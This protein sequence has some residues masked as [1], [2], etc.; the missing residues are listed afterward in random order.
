[1]T[2]TAVLDLGFGVLLTRDA[3]RSPVRRGNAASPLQRGNAEA[4]EIAE[5][6]FEKEHSAQRDS[7]V[8]ASSAFPRDTVTIGASVSNALLARLALLVPVG[9]VVIAATAPRGAD[10]LA[11]GIPAAV[12]LAGA[13]VAYGCLAAALRGWPEWVVPLLAVET[14]G[15]VAQCGGS[16][17]IAAH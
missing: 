8:S 6:S 17:W 2:I 3:A 10:S 13:S 7:A 15:A 9:R 12:L 5:H 4:A 16:W 1:S 11:N 14:G